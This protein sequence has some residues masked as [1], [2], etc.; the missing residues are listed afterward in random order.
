M[1]LYCHLW[2]LW[3]M[4]TNFRDWLDGNLEF[5]ITSCIKMVHK[6][7]LKLFSISTF[8]STKSLKKT[9]KNC[10]RTMGKLF[11]SIHLNINSKS[12]RKVFPLF[13]NALEF[14]LK[15][16]KPIFYIIFFFSCLVLVFVFCS[17]TFV[18]D[19]NFKIEFNTKLYN[20]KRA[21]R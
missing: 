19:K 11:S 20:L 12:S 21:S 15:N 10:G 9:H 14:K 4:E 3:V 1:F 18:D 16:L 8:T 2:K 7:P 13:L 6:K 17:A 5:M